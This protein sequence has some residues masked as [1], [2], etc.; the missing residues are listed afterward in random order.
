MTAPGSGPTGFFGSALKDE[1][2][3]EL[4]RQI[5]NT[6]PDAAFIK[7]TPSD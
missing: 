1:T 4:L 7:N 5:K 2:M 3:L 6:V